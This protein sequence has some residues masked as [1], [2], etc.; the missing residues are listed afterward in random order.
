MDSAS[1]LNDNRFR[2]M[3]KNYAADYSA[4][5]TWLDGHEEETDLS[6]KDYDTTI[7]DAQYLP[8]NISKKCAMILEIYFNKK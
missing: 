8:Q 7:E 3:P 5:I 2:K 1:F 4:K 6:L